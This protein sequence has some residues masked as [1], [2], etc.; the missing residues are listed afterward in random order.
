MKYILDRFEDSLA[1]LE[2]EDQTLLQIPRTELPPDAREGCV[3]YQA[4]GVWSLLPEETRDNAR[5]IRT[6]MDLLW[7]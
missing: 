3:L 4:D 6:K 1:L 7:Q 2:A 5:R